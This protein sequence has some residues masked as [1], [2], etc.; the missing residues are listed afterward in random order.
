M[1]Y[2]ADAQKLV[3]K[4]LERL[5]KSPMSMDYKDALN[6][7]IYELNVLIHQSLQEEV[8]YKDALSDMTTDRYNDI[9]NVA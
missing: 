5:S 8:T 4:W 3:S 9:E 6:D 2:I 7:C 1:I